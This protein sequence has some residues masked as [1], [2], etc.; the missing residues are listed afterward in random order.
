MM[1]GTN[2]PPTTV[3][4]VEDTHSVR[5]MTARLLMAEGFTVLEATGALEAMDLLAH[6][7]VAVA[8][9]DLHLPG[10]SGRDLGVQIG[11]RWPQIEL[12]FVTGDPEAA[13]PFALPGT[14]LFKPFYFEGLGSTVRDLAVH[15]WQNVKLGLPREGAPEREEKP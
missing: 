9:I 10:M 2:L 6:Y 15:Y 12:V 5:Q 3:L 11:A 14:V 7:Q 1:P 4:L 8:I 13:E